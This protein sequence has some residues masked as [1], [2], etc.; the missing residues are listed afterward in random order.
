M[1]DYWKMP[2]YN[3]LGLEE[4]DYDSAKFVVVP[5]PYDSTSSWKT[6]CRDG[7]SS[8]IN[9]SKQ[10]ELFDLD[11]G[12]IYKNGVCTL[13]EIE[14]VRGDVDK[15]IERVRFVVSKILKDK[16]IPALL[17]GE[18]SISIG[19]FNALENVTVLQLDAHADLRDEYEGCRN[20]HAC[21]M[22]RA[23]EKHEIIQVGIR[24]LDKEE[25]EFI[26]KNK[27]KCFF[28]EDTNAEKIADAVKNKDVYVTIDIDVLDPSVAPGVGTPQPDGLSYSELINILKK[29]TATSNVVGFDLVEVLPLQ[30]NWIT[31]FTAA[32]I[33]YKLMG[34]ISGKNLL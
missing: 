6:G 7:P 13:D 24:S 26:E 28:R 11:L 27:I 17:G 9:A 30:N 5:V 32:S 15:T 16:K 1:F 21:V 14:P 25:F 23:F 3:F 29:I 19:A 18:H 4:N 33:I 22:R 2:P 8:I 31:E 10:V 12:E 20:S 34:L